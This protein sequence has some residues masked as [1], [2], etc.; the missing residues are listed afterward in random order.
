MHM[1]MHQQAHRASA[2]LRAPDHF[3]NGPPLGTGAC[4]TLDADGLANA[5]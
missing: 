2:T 4:K 1:N 5:E 3:S